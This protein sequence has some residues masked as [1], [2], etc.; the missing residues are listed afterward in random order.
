MNVTTQIVNCP[1]CGAVAD[2]TLCSGTGSYSGVLPN[3]LHVTFY[4]NNW[5]SSRPWCDCI[6]SGDG[7]WVEGFNL[8]FQHIS[9]PLP[10]PSYGIYNGLVNLGVL[11]PITLM[12]EW[13][14]TYTIRHP[15][16]RGIERVGA[17]VYKQFNCGIDGDYSTGV[18]YAFIITFYCILDTAYLVVQWLKDATDLDSTGTGTGTGVGINGDIASVP[19]GVI[20]ATTTMQ[21]V[22]DNTSPTPNVSHDDCDPPFIVFGIPDAGIFA[23]SSGTGYTVWRQGDNAFTG[24]PPDQTL[25]GNYVPG[26]FD[27]TVG[28]TYGCDPSSL[29]A[30]ITA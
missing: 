9:G 25:S 6:N 23:F 18:Y 24:S 4:L 16:T 26:P 14:R 3:V 8:P 5:T 12:L 19:Y 2:C 11:D 27:P 1:C 22:S 21:A 29:A 15:I 28:G 7:Q 30:L 13:D 20:Y 17:W 10:P